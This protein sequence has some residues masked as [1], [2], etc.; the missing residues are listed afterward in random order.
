MSTLDVTREMMAPLVI[1]DPVKVLLPRVSG[2]VYGRVAGFSG[3]PARGLY[4]IVHTSTPAGTMIPSGRLFV[5]RIVSPEDLAK[6]AEFEKDCHTCPTCGLAP[7]S[8]LDNR[9][10]HCWI[11]PEGVV[12]P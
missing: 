12:R 8:K 5:A 4:P 9:C 1:G 7:T 2:V 10:C 6:F 11:L 3:T